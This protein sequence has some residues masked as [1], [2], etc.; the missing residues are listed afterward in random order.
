M[1]DALASKYLQQ[2]DLHTQ[3]VKNCLSYLSK[4]YQELGNFSAERFE[5]SANRMAILY[6]ALEKEQL[7]LGVEKKWKIKPKLHLFLELAFHFCKERGNPRLF[8]T[9]ADE[10]HGGDLR[11]L[12]KSRGGK[13]ASR[14][15]C[16]R[17]LCRFVYERPLPAA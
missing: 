1:L 7:D 3:T 5:A 13:N 6:C 14:A 9:Y 10:S 15:S 4:C 16:Y 12:A 8:W 17:M 11:E 2:T